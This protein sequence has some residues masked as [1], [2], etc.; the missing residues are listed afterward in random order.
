MGDAIVDAMRCDGTRCDAK[1]DGGNICCDG[2]AEVGG[3]TL[4]GERELMGDDC[5][6]GDGELLQVAIP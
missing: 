6:R 4:G 1:C 3:L 2:D 5:T